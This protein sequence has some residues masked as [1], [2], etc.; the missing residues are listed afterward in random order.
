M[1]KKTIIPFTNRCVALCVLVFIISGI[2]AHR[3]VELQ[4]VDSSNYGRIAASELIEKET[5]PAQ[6]GIIMDRNHMILT[7]NTPHAEL[8]AD[9]YHLRE[10]TSV[11]NGLAYNQVSNSAEWQKADKD[12]TRSKMLQR[13]RTELLHNAR[14]RL[15]TQEKA[16]LRLRAGAS[17][18]S[19][20]QKLEY[21][22][23][24][25]NYYYQRHDLLVAEILYPFLCNQQDV[26]EDGKENTPKRYLTREDIINKI[27]QPETE[28]FNRQALA[29]GE[30]PRSFRNR[31]ILAKNLPLDTAEKIKD[32]LAQAHV[33]GIMVE[34]NAR[35]SYVHPEMLCHVLGYVNYENKGESGV[36]SIYQG[37]LAGQNGKRVYRRNAR[38]QVLPNEEDRY[39][40]PVDGLNLRLTIDMRLQEI[41][42]QE[43]D[44]GMNIY[45][46]KK[47]CMIV[48][49]PKTGD[50]LA[51]VSR[52]AFNL[53]TKEIIT[54]EGAFRRGVLKDSSGKPV[55]GDFNFATQTLYEPGSTFKVV[56]VTA[57]LEESKV[58]GKDSLN[59]N[60]NTVVSCDPFTVSGPK[61][62]I[63]DGSGVNYGNLPMY[64]V[65][66]KSSNPGTARIALK[67]KWHRFK[68]YIDLYGLSQPADISLP[69]AARCLLAD[70][71][72]DV[73]LTRISYG[74][75]VSV[76]PLHMAM[77]YAT[78]AN[79]GVRM[80]PRIIAEITT[81]DGSVYDACPP[82]AAERVMS[83]ATAEELRKALWTVTET[84]AAPNGSNDGR[85]GTGRQGAIPGFRIGGKTGTARKAQRGGYKK[86]YRVSFAAILPVDNPQL[87]VMTVID[88]PSPLVGSIAGGTVAAPIFR[89]AAERFID[90]LNIQPNNPE[91][92]AKHRSAQ[93]TP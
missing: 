73:N 32:A 86:A 42:E 23:E 40:P 47:G 79:N 81:P 58:R 25:C 4:L 56:G 11:V 12:E 46:A 88:E 7:S 77:V 1:D 87:V 45:H 72:R 2:I 30:K 49:D 15:S 91:A 66:K 84:N 43:L 50:I 17:D 29:S 10:I 55:T 39:I 85:A 78:I 82:M 83:P 69:K 27:A 13:M 57:A 61:E 20:N 89:N 51:M 65:L 93:K 22:P 75:S 5:I 14:R 74:Y 33:R 92:Y 38:G 59:M 60:L 48:V 3:L 31:I 54:H 37:Y 26:Q 35:R 67:V 80:K 53:N 90:V 34:S 18:A 16:E 71:S 41:C 24:V 36:E 8:V 70:G 68:K 76:T 21:D 9:R 6:R 64:A 63:T 62:M 44:R 52:P 28:E 19:K